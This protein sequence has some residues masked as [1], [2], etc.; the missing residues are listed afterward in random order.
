M[1]NEY[2]RAYA[3]ARRVQQW[4]IA[5]ALHMNEAVLSRKLRHE[6]SSDD[7]AKLVSIIDELAQKNDAK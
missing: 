3:K 1:A 7:Q 4:R 2:I 5:E 6:L